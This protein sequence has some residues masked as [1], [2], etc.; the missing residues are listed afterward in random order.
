MAKSCKYC[1]GRILVNLNNG[2]CTIIPYPTV[3]D[4]HTWQVYITNGLNPCHS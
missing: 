1:T 2:D 4:K 3:E